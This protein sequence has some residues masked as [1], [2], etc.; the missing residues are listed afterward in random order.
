MQHY[1]SSHLSSIS[2][3][4]NHF[5]VLTK[6]KKPACGKLSICG[7]EENRQGSQVGRLLKCGFKSE[8]LKD[9]LLNF[10]SIHYLNQEAAEL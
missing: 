5:L 7:K 10:I 9:F 3:Y 1:T 4:Q 6:W 2:A 8:L